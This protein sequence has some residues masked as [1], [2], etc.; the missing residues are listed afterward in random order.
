[1]LFFYDSYGNH[2]NILFQTIHFESWCL[3]NKNRLIN[4]AISPFSKYY[5]I[6]KI[7]FPHFFIK[8]LQCLKKIKII[9]EFQY[10][11]EEKAYQPIAP[12]KTCIIA[13]WYFRQHDLILKYKTFFQKKYSL[14]PKFY[15]NNFLYKRINQLDKKKSLL[16]GVHI[17]KGDYKFWQNGKFY[18]E[19]KVYLDNI[20]KLSE[21]IKSQKVMGGVRKK[22]IIRFLLFFQMNQLPNAL[23]N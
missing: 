18:F 4:F 5:G 15:K 9:K 19:D 2:S 17:R 22:F 8:I 10:D 7:P 13:G 20:N 12:V 23:Q 3:E 16:I 21:L 14:K 11:N 1:M 6:R